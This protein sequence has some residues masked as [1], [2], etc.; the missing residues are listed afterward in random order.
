LSI[1]I[2]DNNDSFTYNLVQLIEE[3]GVSDFLVIRNDKLDIDSVSRFS[4]ILISPGPGIPKE[5]LNLF[6]VINR[7]HKTKSILGVCLGHQA[8]AEYFGA[9][10]I[11]LTKPF[12]GVKSEIIVCDNECYLFSD[13]PAKFDGGRYHSWI[14][15]DID[16]PAELKVTAISSDGIIMGISHKAF[17]VHG[18][19]FHPESIMT[20]FG[21]QIIQNWLFF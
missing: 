13:L 17:N 16:L 18:I 12:H 11:N 21:K 20:P 7:Y 5:T 9:K 2:I 14:V 10:L 6:E 15:S 3:C 4:K 1:L 8:I 19:Q